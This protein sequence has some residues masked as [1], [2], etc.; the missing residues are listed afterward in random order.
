MFCDRVMHKNP[1]GADLKRV[2][3]HLAAPKLCHRLG[4]FISITD[5]ELNGTWL[6]ILSAWREVGSVVITRK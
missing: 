5:M 1:T 6:H 4:S 2:H 3:V